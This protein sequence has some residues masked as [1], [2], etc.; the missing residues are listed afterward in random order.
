MSTITVLDS[1]G[2][3]VVVNTPNADG[4]LTSAN[5]RSVVLASDHADVPISAAA[6]TNL[7]A[8]VG[9]LTDAAAAADGTGNYSVISAFKRAL[10][11]GAAMLARI[12]SLVSAVP[13]GN[14]AA[15]PVR[16]VGQN[17]W[18]AGFSSV[19][20]SVLDPLFTTPI[21]GTGV[22]YNQAAGSL[23]IVT[24][25]NTNSEFLTRST[26]TFS[27]AMRL[28]ATIVASQ[29]I[30]NNQFNILLAD[31]IGEGL[32]YNIVSATVLDV[33][34]TAHGF[35][36]QNVGQFVL[37]GGFTGA[38]AVPG[39]YAIASIPDANTIRF[40]VS[41]FPASGTGTC[42]LFGRNYVRN[43][44]DGTTATAIGFD[45]QHN[46]WATGIT[47][48]TTNTTATPGVMIANELS[49][50]DVFMFDSLRASS[51][52][53]DLTSRASRYENI[54]DAA[55]PLYVFLWNLNG[56][57]APASTTTFTLGHVSVENFASAPVYIQGV[58]GQGTVN[59]LPVAATVSGSLTTVTTVSA[60][61]AI[62]NPLPA[63]TNT[64][65]RVDFAPLVPLADV[66]S[67]AITTTATSGAITP[68]IGLSYASQVIVTAVTG[69]TPTLDIRIEESEDG[70]TNWQTVYDF[71]RITANGIYRSPFLPV[72]GNRVRY[73]QTVGGTTP[74]FTRSIQRIQSNAYA[75]AVRQLIDRTIAP[76][77]LNSVTP[78]LAAR[79]SGNA[80]Q[81]VVSMG[82]IAT[83]APAFQLEGSEDLGATFY[84]IGS[85]LTAVA[86]STV[87]VTVLDINASLVRA[88]V[89]TAG[90]GATLGYVVIKAHD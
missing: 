7:D 2:T 23:N 22:T 60:V 5:S 8:D 46:G 40:T 50:R 29:R 67:A 1:G 54:P 38:A 77:T 78:S 9:A 83:T 87:Q 12:P 82:A 68:A 85:P 25:T 74:S 24:G 69:T 30:V 88:R 36:A 6:L 71:P 80:T 49:G 75:I 48:A 59:R 66:A 65:G 18:S 34:K 27:G 72:S 62:T 37:A 21:V 10:L 35:T 4:I 79:D 15:L 70:G 84:A 64:I 55:T 11:N 61:T 28:R 32:T 42:T 89:S 20:S 63:G 86:S 44:V 58:R 3:P 26:E 43:V 45:A 47:A 16:T 19:G 76:N 41:G 31:L 57:T 56:T 51:A 13:A 90:V 81:L 52:T 39:R 73:V 33:T 17:V 53:A 14:A